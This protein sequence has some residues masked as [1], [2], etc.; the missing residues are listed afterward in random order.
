MMIKFSRLVM[1]A[2]LVFGACAKPVTD[3]QFIMTL[4][5]RFNKIQ[6]PE[7]L[8]N[9]VEWAWHDL[10][11]REIPAVRDSQAIF[12]YRGPAKKVRLAGDFTNWQPGPHLI[13]LGKSDI[14]A[15]SLTFPDS[16]RLDYKF[17]VDGQWMLDS[18]NARQMV[19]D[20]GP[21]S[22]LRMPRYRPAP[23]LDIRPET[24]RGKLDTL[25]ITSKALNNTS[26]IQVY[27]PPNYD[28]N[29]RRYP[30]LYLHDGAGY[31]HFAKINVIA[32][33]MIHDGSITPLVIVCVPPISPD[34]R[35]KEHGNK[36]EFAEFFTKELVPLIHSRYVVVD[37]PQQRAICGPNFSGFIAFYIGLRAP[38]FFGKI[39]GQS[40]HLGQD[41][42]AIFKMVEAADLS[43]HEFYFHCGTYETSIGQSGMSFIE[44]NRRMRDRLAAKGARFTYR[45]YPCGHSWGY[46]RD[47]LPRILRKFFE[48][49]FRTS[50]Q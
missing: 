50:N 25:T 27:L 9:E 30:T 32:D 5:A 12:L 22:E 39:A 14:F 49:Q 40:S 3:D 48:T 13:Q 28:T 21:N 20:D 38:Q 35:A 10:K 44:Y 45:E 46:W 42:D 19:G 31:I 33:N 18:S 6:D 26:T 43:K 41:G 23:E 7:K 16:A 11:S 47:E 17:M 24:P 2:A 29:A 15:L 34:E 8:R 4:E 37:D 1:F 36:S